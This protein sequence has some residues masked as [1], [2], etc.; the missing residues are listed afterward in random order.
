M[1]AAGTEPVARTVRRRTAL[2]WAVAAEW[3]KLVS[4]RSTWYLLLGALTLT[5]LVASATGVLTHD[6]G[7]SPGDPAV[8][9]ELNGT[10]LVL[11]S[12][13]ML[14]VT[15]E[16]ATGGAA[17][18]LLCVPDRIRLL[19][20]KA[21]TLGAAVFAAGLAC[22]LLGA[23]C[24]ALALDRST[25]DATG[26]AGQLL[27][28]AVHAALLGMLT[29]GLA[30][31]VRRSAGTITALFALLFLLPVALDP[32]PGAETVI[33]LLPGSASEAWLLGGNGTLERPGGLLALLVWAL[34]AL[35]LAAVVIRRRDA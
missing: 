21:L 24:G 11:A 1:S 34:G 31:V 13:A 8:V 17:T 2:R 7:A 18:A 6:P 5:G 25:F 27:A 22:A 20:A 4:L 19:T 14:A 29:L 30:V 10:C 9:A 26:T 23:V 15:G 33:D 35:L 16:Q 3:T 32:V 12:L 28:V